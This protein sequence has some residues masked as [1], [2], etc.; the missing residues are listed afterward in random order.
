M[1]MGII[2]FFY[3]SLC[4]GKMETNIYLKTINIYFYSLLSK[5]STLRFRMI[6]V[7]HRIRES[8]CDSHHSRRTDA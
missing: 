4:T 7:P 3:N 8:H 6:T 1:K 5:K 2:R